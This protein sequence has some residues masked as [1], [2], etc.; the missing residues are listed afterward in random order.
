MWDLRKNYT[1]HKKDPVAKHIL[2]YTGG[3][4]LNGFTSLKICPSRVKLYASCQDN[5]IYTYNLS[6]Y[7]PE[8]SELDFM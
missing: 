5:T 1:V 7:N 8:P 3:S 4:V 6:S 2:K